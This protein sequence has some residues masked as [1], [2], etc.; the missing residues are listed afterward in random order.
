MKMRYT[1]LVAAAFLALPLARGADAPPADSP[2]MPNAAPLPTQPGAAASVPVLVPLDS[3]ATPAASTPA[4]STTALPDPKPGDSLDSALK[5]LGRPNGQLAMADQVIYMFSRGTVTTS[6]NGLVEEVN[7]TPLANYQAMK[8]DEAQQQTDLAATRVRTNALLEMLLSDPAYQALATRDRILA[9]DKFNRDHPGSD[10]PQ[11]IKDLTAIYSAE[12]AVQTQ[13]T[14]L[15]K[16]NKQAQDQTTLLQQRLN[17]DEKQLAALRQRTENAEQQAAQAAAA[18]PQQIISDPLVVGPTLPVMSP[19]V[20]KAGAN[21]LA[22][23]PGGP[24]VDQAARPVIINGTVKTPSTTGLWVMQPDGTI[25][26]LPPA[27]ESN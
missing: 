19:P 15:E 22:I 27:P 13:L 26:I 11:D 25:K 18:L 9:L 8:A 7:L 6:A 2:T 21:G 3:P 1:P 12:Q 14:A 17:D 4:A 20:G 16:K 10:A 24:V 5:A 23:T